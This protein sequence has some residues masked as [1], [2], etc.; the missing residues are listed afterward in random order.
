MFHL[1]LQITVNSEGFFFSPLLKGTGRKKAKKKKQAK[2]YSF[3]VGA[4][5]GAVSVNFQ[6]HLVI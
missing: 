1:D 6:L 4:G 5:R 2:R 3:I